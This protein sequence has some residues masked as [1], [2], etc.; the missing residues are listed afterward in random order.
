MRG[1]GEEPIAMIWRLTVAVVLLVVVVGGIVGFNMFRDQAIQGYFATMQPPPVTV[2]VIEAKAEPWQ[3]ELEAIGTAN[4]AQGVDLGIEASGIVR[5]ILFK[6]NDRVEQ[7]QKL[8]Q[9]DDRVERADLEAARAQ[10]DL[11]EETLKR[12]EALRERGVVPISDLDVARADMANASAE[13]LKLQ[14]VLEQKALEAPFSGMIGIPKLEVGGYVEPG[15]VYATLQD[16]DTMRVDFSIPEQQIRLIE[17]GMPVIVSSEV[18]GT[19]LG[20]EIVAIEPK[21]DPNSRLVGVRAVVEEAN[22][23]I[24]PGQ[25]L[26]VRVQQPVE[27]SVIALPQTTVTSNLY[28]DSVYVVRK[29]GEAEDAPLK[30]EQVFVDAG[31]RARGLV[32]IAKGLEPGDQ[33]VTAGQNR[34][35][36][37]ATVVVDNTVNPATA[38]ASAAATTVTD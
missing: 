34:L 38:D 14:A 9:I 13:V 4:A 25:F 3:P 27:P 5:E 31:R 24:N 32:E 29:D 15:T 10:L 11:A 20:G 35:S 2:S 8:I 22:G 6:A 7:G 37:G 19:E 36:G 17:I 12:V 26:R 30:V 28:G 21:I 16:I 23:Q 18:G 1:S 33:V